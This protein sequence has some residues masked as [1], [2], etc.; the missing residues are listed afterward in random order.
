MALAAL[1]PVGWGILGG[2]LL[3]AIC[4][5]L[6][7]GY[8]DARKQDKRAER[9]EKAE[10][11]ERAARENKEKEC[12]LS[13]NEKKQILDTELKKIIKELTDQ[14]IAEY[15]KI[16]RYHTAPKSNEFMWIN[17]TDG[18]THN[19][20]EDTYTQFK[21]M[22]AEQDTIISDIID[23]NKSELNEFYNKCMNPTTNN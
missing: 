5:V 14:R 16:I 2:L 17:G 22:K 4:V 23:A 18:I 13:K 15:L 7:Y 10:R 12:N 19:I 9:E 1:G 3:I 21:K 11:E 20:S 8:Y 6:A